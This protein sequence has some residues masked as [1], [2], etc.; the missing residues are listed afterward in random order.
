MILSVGIGIG[1]TVAMGAAFWPDP[2]MPAAVLC[3]DEETIKT[4][5]AQA[6]LALDEAFSMHIER[7]YEVWMKDD[8]ADQAQ[9]VARG[10][11]RAVRVYVHG[12]TAIRK[13]Q[14]SCH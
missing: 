13:W 7:L 8:T 4:L 1:A 3:P 9:R 6:F 11:E 2:P 5:R 12:Q 14:P 10:V